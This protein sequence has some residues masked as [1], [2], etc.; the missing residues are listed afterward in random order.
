MDMNLHQMA[1]K[2]EA[3]R[4]EQWEQDFLNLLVQGQVDLVHDHPQEGPDGWPYMLVKTDPN[5]KE[6]TRNLIYWLTQNG[7]G[8]VINA[9]KEYP[10]YI[11]SYG[12]LWNFRERGHFLNPDNVEKPNPGQFTLLQGSKI[13]TGNPSSEYLPA[14]VRGILKQFLN[15]QGVKSPKVTMLSLDGKHFDMAFSLE[16]LGTPPKEEHKGIMEALSWFL[17]Y[18]YSLVIASEKGLPAFFDL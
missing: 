8:L 2:P 15:D 9:H 5:A 6:P 4:N 16:S 12:M 7:V 10:D 14:Y 3:F 13:F 1:Q 11:F 17:P 18:G